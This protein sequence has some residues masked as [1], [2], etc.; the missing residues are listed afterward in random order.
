MNPSAKI[1]DRGT[2]QN[3][4]LSFV[5]N[6]ML[7]MKVGLPEIFAE[8]VREANSLFAVIS[9]TPAGKNRTRVTISMLGFGT[10]PGWDA[11]YRIFKEC[12]QD[13]LVAM[14]QRFKNG[15][16]NWVKNNPYVKHN[17]APVVQASAKKHSH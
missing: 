13:T 11:A 9:L 2:I 15:P 12:V 3:E 16:I 14:Q 10:G 1:G 17:H 5:P 6:R 8:E 7:S 4:I